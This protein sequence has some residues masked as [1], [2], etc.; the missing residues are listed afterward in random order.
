[1]HPARP[2]AT[3]TG[4]IPLIETG[5]VDAREAAGHLTIEM[6]DLVETHETT[7]GT[8]ETETGIETETETVAM[9]G[10]RFGQMT[11]IEGVIAT[12]PTASEV[13]G[14]PMEAKT[15]DLLGIAV[16]HLLL[17]ANPA[18]ALTDQT[19]HPLTRE[20]AGKVCGI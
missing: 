17:P 19:L 9:A 4:D 10:P 20:S 11:G 12:G 7:T 15:T 5:A 18:R 2:T 16:A 1:M 8:T 14:V 6:T 13:V 3:G